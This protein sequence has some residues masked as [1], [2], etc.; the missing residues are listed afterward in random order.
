MTFYEMAMTSQY[1]HR[2]TDLNT[3]HTDREE[4]TEPKVSGD[5]LKPLTDMHDKRG[6]TDALLLS[7]LR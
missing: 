5:L 1:P 4:H 6:D 2:Y 3:K 7:H